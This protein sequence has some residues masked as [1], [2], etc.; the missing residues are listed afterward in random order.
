MSVAAPA[1]GRT[2]GAR[3]PITRAAGEEDS[4]MREVDELLSSGDEAGTR[5]LDLCFRLIILALAAF[6]L[7][8]PPADGAHGATDGKTIATTR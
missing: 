1:P 7:L 4:L 2:G 8:M 6:W 5:W 3:R